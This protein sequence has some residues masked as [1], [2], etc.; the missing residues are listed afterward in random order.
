M[1]SVGT[2]TDFPLSLCGLFRKE[3]S[4]APKLRFIKD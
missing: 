3:T 4:P 2:Q 1:K